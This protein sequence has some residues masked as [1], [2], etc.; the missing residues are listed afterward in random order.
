[1]ETDLQGTDGPRSADEVRAQEKVTIEIRID[2]ETMTAML[3]ERAIMKDPEVEDTIRR[4]LTMGLLFAIILEPKEL[5]WRPIH[6]DAMTLTVELP[7]AAALQLESTANDLGFGR[8]VLVATVLSN[9]IC[10]PTDVLAAED[11]QRHRYENKN[12]IRRVPGKGNLYPVQIFMPGYQLVFIRMLANGEVDRSVIIDEAL[13]ALARQILHQDRV[14]GI[15]IP[16]EA[17]VFAR[18]I[19]ELQSAD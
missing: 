15:D 6:R 1:M 3:R 17:R 11:R 19:L 13:V 12:P 7:I 9:E 5:K 16:V 8:D 4:R 14:A 2:E 18:K 10:K